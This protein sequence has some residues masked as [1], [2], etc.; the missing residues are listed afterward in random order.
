MEEGSKININATGQL[1]LF[2]S[3]LTGCGNI[4]HGLAVS[5]G[6]TV[7][8]ENNRIEDALYGMYLESES[9]IH[10][11]YNDFVNN[12]IGISV[13]SPFESDQF[14]IVVNQIGHI[15]G[16]LFFT[17]TTLSD[18]MFGI[19]YYPS[20]PSTPAEIP[21]AKGFA[22]VYLA[23]SVSLNI[24]DPK[25]EGEGRNQIFNMRNG[26]IM[27]FSNSY[28]QGNDFYDFEGNVPNVYYHPILDINQAGI[29]AD[30]TTNVVRNNTCTN[31]KIGYSGSW[32]VSRIS[33]NIFDIFDDPADLEATRGIAVH[34]PQVFEVTDNQIINGY[35]GISIAIADELLMTKT[36]LSGAIP[37]EVN[38][39][40]PS[41]YQSP[42]I[43]DHT[44]IA[45]HGVLTLYPNPVQ[46]KLTVNALDPIMELVISGI[47]GQ[48][49]QTIR[50]NAQRFNIDLNGLLN[51][52]Y[53]IISHLE[54]NIISQKSNVHR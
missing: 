20:W 6:G 9:S 37:Y 22:A 23:G 18:P 1:E 40:P 45:M 17:E 38:C 34:G 12:F 41:P 44:A 33:D 29:Y 11:A 3:Y 8:A 43:S 35:K 49:Y 50:P 51:G 19:P 53:I 36:G 28:I 31:L 24:G 13:G 27:R 10:C 25:A 5:A 32:T 30:F 48:V 42:I 52:L 54:N 4:W 2:N 14:N 26:I 47:T 21:Y 39:T 15:K 16:N 7:M 46:D